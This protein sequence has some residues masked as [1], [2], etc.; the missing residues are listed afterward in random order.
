MAAIDNENHHDE[1]NNNSFNSQEKS[2][3][4]T[5]TIIMERGWFDAAT[6]AAIVASMSLMMPSVKMRSTEYF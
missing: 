3:F 1:N 6:T 5:P 4:P 2:S